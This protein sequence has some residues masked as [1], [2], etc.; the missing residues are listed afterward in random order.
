MRGG[1]R[2]RDRGE[3]EEEKK[4]VKEEEMKNK[5]R[6]EDRKKKGLPT[7]ILLLILNREGR[8]HNSSLFLTD[9][10]WPHDGLQHHSLGGTSFQ[11]CSRGRFV[12][13][14]WHLRGGDYRPIF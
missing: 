1:D 7:V 9:A 10:R 6:E 11:T 5:D 4:R 13:Q 3:R 14:L 12:R 2:E 8:G